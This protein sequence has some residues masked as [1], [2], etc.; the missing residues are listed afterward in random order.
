MISSKL[1]KESE[2][3]IGDFIFIYLF[4]WSSRRSRCQKSSPWS[5]GSKT[6]SGRKERTIYTPYKEKTTA[7]QKV[8]S[9]KAIE[10]RLDEGPRLQRKH[11]DENEAKQNKGADTRGRRHG[12]CKTN[13]RRIQVRATCGW[14][15]R[16]SDP[17]RVRLLWAILFLV[18]AVTFGHTT[19]C[20]SPALATSAAIHLAMKCSAPCSAVLRHPPL[21][22]AAVVHWSALM[23]KAL[24]SSR[25]YLIHS[26][27]WPPT[28]PAPPTK[29]L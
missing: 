29:G 11:E 2:R 17:A 27:S 15:T 16:A 25:K 1:S 24:R 19:A 3:L 21:S 18:L 10:G 4:L 8:Y 26:F 13:A 6:P 23:P 20:R 14:S 5:Q 12:I 28:Q 9:E 7:V 22:W